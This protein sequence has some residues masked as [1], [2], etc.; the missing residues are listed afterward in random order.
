MIATT[1]NEEVEGNFKM[2]ILL[3]KVDLA[4]IW[5]D[6]NL[7]LLLHPEN[8]IVSLSVSLFDY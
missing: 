1:Q 8:M 5:D 2:S 3:M 4:D 7:S 6:E